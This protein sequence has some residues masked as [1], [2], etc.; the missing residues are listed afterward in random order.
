MT[1]FALLLMPAALKFWP[2]EDADLL[3]PISILTDSYRAPN[4]ESLRAEAA[5]LA[6]EIDAL[7]RT[8]LADYSELSLHQDPEVTRSFAPAPPEPEALISPADR[9][10]ERLLRLKENYFGNSPEA[11]ALMEFFESTIEESNSDHT[12]FLGQ[13]YWEGWNR[14]QSLETAYHWFSRSHAQGN[15]RA[16][17]PLIACHA[18]GIGTRRDPETAMW[19]RAELLESFYQPFEIRRID[20]ILRA[21]RIT[22]PL[23]S[24]LPARGQTPLAQ[25]RPVFPP[26]LRRQGIT[27]ETI[28]TFQVD[29]AGFTHNLKPTSFTHPEF[30]RAATEALTFWRVAARVNPETG[31]SEEIRVPIIF[32]IIDDDGSP[33]N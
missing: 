10:F 5:R 15:P 9:L 29:A 1:L 7:T 19:L 2:V 8:N 25:I 17:L 14:P 30:A 23:F 6:R 20:Q 18:F 27:G 21:G 26:A 31:L 16:V 24:D 28:M 33:R 12:H 11:D 22:P 13:A 4:A 32:N 3:A